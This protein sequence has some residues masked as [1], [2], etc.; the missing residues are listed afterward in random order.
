M[1]IDEVVIGTTPRKSDDSIVIVSQSS[2][3]VAS[4]NGAIS[5]SSTPAVRPKDTTPGKKA[6]SPVAM[7]SPSNSKVSLKG[8]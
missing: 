1:K 2:V 6:A 8:S 5:S 7:K 4:D 3:E